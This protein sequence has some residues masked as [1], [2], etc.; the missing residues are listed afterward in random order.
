MHLISHTGAY[1]GARFIYMNTSQVFGDNKQRM[2]KNNLGREN[3]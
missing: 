1:V 3:K 2:I